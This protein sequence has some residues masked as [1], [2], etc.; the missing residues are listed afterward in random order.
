MNKIRIAAILPAFIALPSLL[1][2][3]VPLHISHHLLMDPNTAF[4]LIAVCIIWFYFLSGYKYGNIIMP[5]MGLI[6]VP[7]TLLIIFSNATGIDF[8]FEH[9]FFDPHK[10]APFMLNLAITF[11]GIYIIEIIYRW[12]PKA[13]LYVNALLAITLFVAILSI[14]GHLYNLGQIVTS[15]LLMPI[16]P[17]AILCFLILSL[18]IFFHANKIHHLYL[19][20]KII[21]SFVMMFVAIVGANIVVYKNFNR[22]ASVTNEI[23]KTRQTLIEVY[24]ID[25]QLDSMQS[26]AKTYEATGSLAKLQ[27]YNRGKQL[28]LDAMQHLKAVALQKDDQQIIQAVAG[29]DGLGIKILATT[30]RIT[31]ERQH[32]I[33]P[34]ASR[35]S[36]DEV[37]DTYRDQMLN[38]IR[39]L[40]A[41]YSSQ[42]NEMVVAGAYGNRGIVTGVSISSALSVLL[43]IFT[44]LFIR[45]TIRKLYLTQERLKKSYRQQ[46][47]ERSRAQAVL[48]SIG[49][50]ILAIDPSNVV[51]IFN[52]AAEKITGLKADDVVGTGYG[53]VL[54][55]TAD[56]GDKSLLDFI[57]K[58]LQG[59]QSQVSHVS[60]AHK[61][62]RRVEL[63]ISASPVKTTQ[64]DVV[65][66]IIVFRDRT[67][68]QALESAK[69][70]F[71]AL[72]SHQLRTPATA[73]KQFLAM[74]LQGY[75]GDITERQRMFLQEAYDNNELGLNIIEELL[76]IAR[77]E[78]NQIK[79]E[80]Q[81]VNA[82]ELLQKEAEQHSAL[83]AKNKQ[84]IILDI[85]KTTITIFADPSMLSMVLDNLITN[86]LK[87]TLEGGTI[88]LRLEK[89]GHKVIIAVSDTGIG[90]K[91]ADIPKIFGRFSR[92][93]DPHKQHVSGTGIGLYLVKKIVDMHRAKIK[94]ESE[95]GKGT[96]FTVEFNEIQEG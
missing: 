57:P 38:N 78:S 95:Y 42:L 84:T 24:E 20:R 7:N 90:I 88:G 15:P 43:I 64:G 48:T 67:A 60:I 3:I 49:D 77:L 10:A 12:L 21:L 26:D 65:G 47:E 37:L 32:G 4:G 17:A 69:D 59:E 34:A 72:A 73:T 23:T 71:V 91:K 2:N 28:Y 29:V 56:N 11:T 27:E 74:F 93:E 86:A 22:T 55:F 18:A 13:L 16:P 96:T 54:H 68:E 80:K 61:S 31:T 8:P 53:G 94:V 25:I 9:I 85:P 30:D 50:G 41:I 81:H 45:Q 36:N 70:E 75:A 89:K 87:Y 52:Q 1:Q 66:A 40:T 83:A 46:Y 76:N 14:S 82:S 19:N 44:P 79:I 6:S 5:I 58:A 39:S 92:L 35:T 62:G 51:I 33:L 63:Q